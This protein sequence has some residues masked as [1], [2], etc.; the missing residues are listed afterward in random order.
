MDLDLVSCASCHWTEESVSLVS[1]LL[2]QLLGRQQLLL[3]LQVLRDTL[4]ILG[5]ARSVASCF[6]RVYSRS[7]CT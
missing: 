6:W 2:G 4:S 3:D 1:P 7:A 5:D